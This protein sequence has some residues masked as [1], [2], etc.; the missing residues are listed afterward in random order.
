MILRDISHD[1]LEEEQACTLGQ[2]AQNFLIE[3]EQSLVRQ[4]SLFSIT[5]PNSLTMV[6]KGLVT[7]AQVTESSSELQL[8][9]FLESF[10]I[11]EALS[12][13]QPG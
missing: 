7:C 5:R 12:K 11:W 10:C 13:I 2:D 3:A 8:K 6:N 1:G 9:R 4:S